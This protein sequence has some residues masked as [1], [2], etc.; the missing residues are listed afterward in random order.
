MFLP[1]VDAPKKS[2]SSLFSFLFVPWCLCGYTP[3]EKSQKP[4]AV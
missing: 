1:Q 4:D 3:W 2:A